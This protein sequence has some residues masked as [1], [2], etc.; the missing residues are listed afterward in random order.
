MNEI[1]TIREF[2]GLHLIHA[3]KI[4]AGW[5]GGQYNYITNLVPF[6]H[7]NIEL[8]ATTAVICNINE[9]CNENLIKEQPAAVFIYYCGDVAEGIRWSKSSLSKNIPV[10]LLNSAISAAELSNLLQFSLNLK[11]RF[12]PSEY[13]NVNFLLGKFDPVVELSICDLLSV[14][15]SAAV[16]LLDK[17]FQQIDEGQGQWDISYKFQAIEYLHSCYKE[18][19][20]SWL[21]IVTKFKERYIYALPLTS[22]QVVIGY[23][24]VI[25]IDKKFEITDY[26]VLRQVGHFGI[27]SL[28]L[29]TKLEA[30]E[31]CYKD[32]FIYDL[33][34]NNFK[35]S[36][37]LRR[38][39]L[40]WGID[41]TQKY[42]LFVVQPDEISSKEVQ[43]AILVAIEQLAVQFFE[44]NKYPCIS[45]IVHDQVVIIFN[46]RNA[47]HKKSVI[48]RLGEALKIF[49]Q[50]NAPNETISLG[51]GRFY[52][53]I[54]EVYK[55]YE[56]AKQALILAAFSQAKAKVS[57][58]EDL[59]I[60][61]LL[62]QLDKEKLQ[63]YN[64]ML[65]G[66]LIVYDQQ[67]ATDY[68]H[69]L[70][71]YFENNAN[72]NLTAEKIFMHPNTVR[73]HLKKI[74]EI[75]D[76]ELQNFNDCL[77][78]YLACKT[79]WIVNLK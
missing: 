54:R 15:F 48:K 12:L 7:Y 77:Q 28:M 79:Y 53:G 57:H 36:S 63:Q 67:N 39:F 37:E 66:K 4:V 33:L 65:I 23:L 74:E 5:Q 58:F 11:K 68:L 49:V 42:Q 2:I 52:S 14:Y 18:A 46:C 10:I 60:M 21:C 31:R 24:T 55:S 73:N 69:L 27:Q 16:V 72:L 62:A 17:D 41:F 13:E 26:Q 78:I 75:L 51:I 30:V 59:G 47:E 1:L 22:Q 20:N 38:L 8:T 43:E 44:I 19:P 6:G 40:R 35:S 45:A 61:A 56:E 34:Y 76:V 70:Q 9:I 71:I 3:V 32:N 25:G 50:Q 29:E 64:K